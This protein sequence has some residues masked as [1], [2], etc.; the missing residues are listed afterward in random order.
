LYF[1]R[2]QRKVLSPAILYAIKRKGRQRTPFRRLLKALTCCRSTNNLSSLSDGDRLVVRWLLQLGVDIADM[3]LHGGDAYEPVSRR[4]PDWNP[5]FDELSTSSLR[6]VS[7][8]TRAAWDGWV[9]PGWWPTWTAVQLITVP[10]LRDWP[11]KAIS[12]RSPSSRNNRTYPPAVPARGP[13]PELSGA[14]RIL[15]SLERERFEDQDFDLQTHPPGC[16]ACRSNRSDSARAASYRFG[17]HAR[18]R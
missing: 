9:M 10:T 7:G 11:G 16:S 2:P 5:G 1:S 17:Q 12:Y 13:S 6:V 3:T 8:S 14:L 15:S 4:F 18:S